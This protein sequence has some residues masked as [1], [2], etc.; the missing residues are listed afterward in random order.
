MKRL[1]HLI[2]AILKFEIQLNFAVAENAK[3]TDEPNS[4]S[5]TDAL[6]TLDVK[7]TSLGVNVEPTLSVRVFISGGGLR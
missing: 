4:S 2:P 7:Q 3:A 1:F 6:V 5:Y